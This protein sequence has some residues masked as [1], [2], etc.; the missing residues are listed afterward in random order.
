MALIFLPWLRLGIGALNTTHT[1]REI[2]TDGNVTVRQTARRNVSIK[3]NIR[4]MPGSLLGSVD[5]S[6][7]LKG[8]GEVVG[9]SE[10]V[11]SLT[12]PAVNETSFPPNQIPYVD[13]ADAD[14]PWRYSH[15]ESDAENKLRPWL[16]LVV[17]NKSEYNDLPPGRVCSMI[18]VDIRFLPDPAESWAFA[19]VQASVLPGENTA[20][21]KEFIRN[22]PGRIHSRLVCT[23]KLQA[24]QSYTAFLV[25]TYKMGVNAALELDVGDSADFAW[26]PSSAAAVTLPYYYRW[27]FSTS[28]TGDFEEL[29]RRIKVYDDYDHISG[30]RKVEDSSGTIMD[31]EGLV[32]PNDRK[33]S[34]KKYNI[35]FSKKAITMF[36]KMYAKQRQNIN[37]QDEE[38]ELFIPLYGYNHA[39]C[40]CLVAPTAS[41]TWENAHGIYNPVYDH[42]KTTDLW[43]SEVNLDRNFRY[44]AALG[45]AVVRYN[46]DDFVSRCFDMVGDIGEVNSLQKRY[47]TLKNVRENIIKRH[48]K[49]MDNMRFMHAAKNLQKYYTG[50]RMAASNVHVDG[51]TD[52]SSVFQC[53]HSSS[54]R[55]A[56]N[57]IKNMNICSCVDGFR[58]ERLMNFRSIDEKNKFMDDADAFKDILLNTDIE[59]KILNRIVTGPDIAEIGD[60]EVFAVPKIEDG[61]FQH[62]PVGILNSLIPGLSELPNNSSMLLC[63]NREF[64]EAFMLGANHEM[65]RELIWREFPIKRRA[66]VFNSFWGANGT[67]RSDIKDIANWRGRLGENAPGAGADKDNIIVAIKSDL[68]RRFPKTLLYAVEYDPAL[69][70]QNGW[71]VVLNVVKS[72]VSRTGAKLHNPLFSLDVMEGLMFIYYD[73]TKQYMDD[74][75]N[76]SNPGGVRKFCF[77]ILENVSL[78]KFGL[79]ESITT[80]KENL[81]DLSWCDFDVNDTSG[82][83]NISTIQSKLESMAFS[84][85]NVNRELKDAARMAVITLNRPSGVIMDFS[86]IC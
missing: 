30:S 68:F 28:E 48:L 22:N 79:D 54:G 66:T 57:L 1:K 41:G 33:P 60:S 58:N 43:F 50:A 49:T 85:P 14:F 53:Q 63:L 61:L 11:I 78:P 23:R 10:E 51:S 19:H 34:D 26:N 4:D 7:T 40:E 69:I 71:S 81:N 62:I 52:I 74:A 80:V 45:A 39:D 18:S 12:E 47:K 15:E 5:N 84:N 73:F 76:G 13:F 82:Y 32:L 31:F 25:P 16:L 36:N 8:P 59:R 9:F 72:G 20:D 2:D 77:V 64:L 55:I 35:D 75:L 3:A 56:L 86:N 37:T 67:N 38:P 65:V 24:F 27:D 46:Q 83:L 70:A 6:F 17:L 21:M 44:A 42:A 29:A